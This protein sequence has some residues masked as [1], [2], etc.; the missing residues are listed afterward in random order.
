MDIC[1]V[2]PTITSCAIIIIVSINFMFNEK[3]E[4]II[5]TY[6]GI[7]VMFLFMTAIIDVA[8][9]K[10]VYI[11]EKLP[12]KEMSGDEI[13]TPNIGI[14]SQEQTIEKIDE[15]KKEIPQTV[16]IMTT[17]TNKENIIQTILP[18]VLKNA[19]SF[20]K[21]NQSA[22]ESLVNIL[23]M[24]DTGGYFNPIS[25][26]GVI[27]DPRGIIL[28]NAHVAQY[29]LLRDYITKDFIKCSIRMG[30]PSKSLYV[31]EPLYISEK[32]ITNNSESIIQKNYT[33]NGEND[34]AFLII[35]GTTNEDNK[36]P[37]YFPYTD[38]ETDDS[39]TGVGDNVLIAGYPAGFLGGITIQKDLNIVTTIDQI[40]KFYTFTEN[41]LDLIS[42]GGT[43]LAQKGSSG[44]GVI[45]NENKLI[46][47]VVTTTDSTLTEERD[48]RAIT[49]SHINRALWEEIGID[50]QTFLSF[51][52]TKTAEIFN[53]DIAPTLKGILLKALEK[54]N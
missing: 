5:K 6:L 12:Y 7:L 18:V 32:W 29:F 38:Y 40:K 36:L 10:E 47:L 23:C 4:S 37:D 39:K 44:G 16:N 28:T 45:N 21:I 15:P 13:K 14:V 33:E 52:A 34:Y 25:G 22:R 35:T 2:K 26:S 19:V 50:I 41:Q 27:I 24:T 42:V 46:A 48:L 8:Q 20:E 11:K 54:T 3:T 43:L 53:Q 30:S 17:P 9:E 1:C 51:N 31:A 49:L